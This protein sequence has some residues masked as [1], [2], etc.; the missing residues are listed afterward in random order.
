MTRCCCAHVTPWGTPSQNHQELVSS[1]GER[2]SLK[3]SGMNYNGGYS[4]PFQILLFKIMTCR[5]RQGFASLLRRKSILR[6]GIRGKHRRKFHGQRSITYHVPFLEISFLKVEFQALC[7]WI[8]GTLT[9]C[10]KKGATLPS[11]S[12]A[13]EFLDSLIGPTKAL[14][15]T[16]CISLVPLC[17]KLVLVVI[18]L[19]VP[20]ES[21]KL[22]PRALWEESSRRALVPGL[23]A[24]ARLQVPHGSAHGVSGPRETLQVPLGPI[25]LI[26]RGGP[27][28]QEHSRC[29]TQSLVLLLLFAPAILLLLRI[30][31]CRDFTVC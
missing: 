15:L 17:S 27:R 22:C 26:Y 3:T 16:M 24:S 4:G 30:S 23:S 13:W 2:R 5:F 25:S 31:I 20:S 12:N 11:G 1:V 6:G 19:H 21:L 7:F 8:I 10:P 18:L 9:F 14:F 29:Y 28:T